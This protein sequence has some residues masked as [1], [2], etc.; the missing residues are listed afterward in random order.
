[1]SQIENKRLT[2]SGKGENMKIVEKS[3]EEIKPY[4]RNPR[5]NDTAVPYVRESIKRYGFKVPIVIDKNGVIVAG[6]TRYLACVEL[7]MSTVPCIVADDLTDEE[8]KEFR[9]VDNKVAEYA[10]WDKTLLGI[11]LDDI[12]GD[13]SVFGF[14]LDKLIE[15]NI[16]PEVPFTEVLGEEHN[17][18]VLYFDN[19]VDWLQ[20]ESLL[21]IG[22]KK[23][24]STRKDG[25]ITKNMERKS[26]GRVFKGKEVLER[27]REHY[28]D[29]H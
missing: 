25:K 4:E 11:E 20:M 2:F 1:M 6:H 13:I 12:V 27:L 7:G 29:I 26:I 24:L 3:I 28:E 9:L 19:D 17:Y 10:T 21:D 14:E 22:E 16:R 15:Q 5:K 23:N 18:I 8:I